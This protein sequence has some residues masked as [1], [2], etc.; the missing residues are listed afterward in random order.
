MLLDAFALRLAEGHAAAA[1]ALTRALELLVTVDADAG[2]ARRWLWLAS[3]RASSLIALELWDFE[4]WRALAVRQVQVARDVGALVQLQSALNFLGLIHL[5]AGEASAAEQLIEEDLLIAE[6]TGNP[7]TGYG[8]MMLAAWQG[9][10]Q[11]ASELIQ[12]AAQIATGR[13]RAVLAFE[14]AWATAVLDNGLG[15]YDAARAAAR[16]AFERD[17]LAL[18]HLVVAELAEAAAR[19]GDTALVQATLDWLSERTRVTRTEWVLGIEARVRALLSDG[20]AADELLPGVG[21]AAGPD[22]A[23]RRAGPVAPA[24]RGVAAPA[25]P[26]HGRAGAAAH[27]APDAGRDGHGG[28]RRAGAA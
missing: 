19:T 4:S 17:E 3:G 24:V 2:E 21:R 13:G 6:A 28:V 10:E 11:E 20:Q 14:A 1:A 25:G 18:G 26:P 27:R 9:R 16:Q 7:P 23:P 12:A 22:P 5:F 15:R 8:A